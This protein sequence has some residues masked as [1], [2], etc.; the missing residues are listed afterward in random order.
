MKKSIICRN[1]NIRVF[2]YIPP[3]MFGRF[4]DLS[5]HTY[6]A[7]KEDQRLKTHISL[8]EEDLILK[9]KLKEET[10]WI[11][12]DNL[13]EFGKIRPIDMSIKWPQVEVKNITSPPKGRQ[14]KNVHNI[15]KSS[16]DETSPAAKRMKSGPNEK[17]NEKNEDKEEE[18]TQ[19][20][21]AFVKKLEAKSQKKFNQTK[22]DFP[23]IK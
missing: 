20:V 4:T 14:R 9:T 7:R 16:D 8:G 3:Q 5:R 2:P 21:V 22:L 6:I 23:K 18:R 11:V 17:V 19:K 15:S 13:E 1:K 12:V 10:E